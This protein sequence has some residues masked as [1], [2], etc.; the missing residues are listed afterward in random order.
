MRKVSGWAAGP[1]EQTA[2][3]WAMHRSVTVHTIR[4]ADMSLRIQ[5]AARA[6]ILAAGRGLVTPCGSTSGR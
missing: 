5:T 2:E 6:L 3:Q 1:Y 4:D